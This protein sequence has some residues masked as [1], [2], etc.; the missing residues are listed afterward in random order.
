MME[1]EIIVDDLRVH[2]YQSD[3]FDKEKTIVFLKEWAIIG[4]TIGE[5]KKRKYG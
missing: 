5:H 1:K 3:S 2:Y 4:H